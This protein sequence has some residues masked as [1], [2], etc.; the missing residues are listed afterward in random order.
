M[1]DVFPTLASPIKT[2][3]TSLSF[4]FSTKVDFI[5]LNFSTDISCFFNSVMVKHLL[6]L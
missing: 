3:F 1:S 5:F 2:T 4:I 6:F